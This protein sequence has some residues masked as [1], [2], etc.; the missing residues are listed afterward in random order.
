MKLDNRAVAQL[1]DDLGSL[2]E[3]QGE[4]AFRVNAY[5]RAADTLCG[6]GR[7]LAESARRRWHNRLSHA[8]PRWKV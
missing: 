5:H 3:L 1:F 8:R 2:L 7:Q 4:S 6:L